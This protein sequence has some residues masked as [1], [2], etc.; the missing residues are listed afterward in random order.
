MF[1]FQREMRDLVL[2]ANML[3]LNLGFI[4]KMNTSWWNILNF[5][6]NWHG[7]GFVVGMLEDES[8]TRIRLPPQSN[9]WSHYLYLR[10]T[11]VWGPYCA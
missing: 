2:N 7:K 4:I 3:T 1:F 6:I 8:I 10:Y 5:D 9:S 11:L